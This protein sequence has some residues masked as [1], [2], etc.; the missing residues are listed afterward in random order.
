MILMTI[1]GDFMIKILLVEDTEKLSS[2]IIEYLSGDFQITAVFNGKDAITYLYEGEFDLV[3]LDLMLPVIDGMT[4]LNYIKEKSYNASVII[5]TAKEEIGEKL[6]AF[7]IGANDYLTKPFFME[8]LKARIYAILR[9]TGKVTTQNRVTFKNLYLDLKKQ[10]CYITKNGKDKEIELTE[11]LFRLL[12]YF[13]INK[14]IL[15]F[16]EQIFNRICGFDSEA[17]DSIIEV[18]ISHLRKKLMPYGYDKYIVTKRGAGY[19]FNENAK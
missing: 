1:E 13:M 8:E 10:K 5:L 14:G 17:W 4:V 2:N 7:N 15:L 19:I 6:R 11:K 16:K 12:E 3:I 18:Y 9:S